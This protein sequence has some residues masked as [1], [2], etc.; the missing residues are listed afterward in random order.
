MPK[1]G[2]DRVPCMKTFLYTGPD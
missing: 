1:F 2:N